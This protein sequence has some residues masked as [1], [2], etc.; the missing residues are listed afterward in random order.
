MWYMSLHSSWVIF[1]VSGRVISISLFSC[2]VGGIAQPLSYP[3]RLPIQQN[4]SS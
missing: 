1:G 3:Q 4:Q 2:D